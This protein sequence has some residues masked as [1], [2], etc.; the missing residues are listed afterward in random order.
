MKPYALIATGNTTEANRCQRILLNL[1]YQV[2]VVTT[3]ARAQVQ[4]AFSTPD[5]ILLDMDL[6]DMPGE[7]VLRQINAQRRMDTTALILFSSSVE[8]IPEVHRKAP[9]HNLAHPVNLQQLSTFAASLSS[10]A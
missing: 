3:G 8:F 10:A 5:L 4:L 2:Q 6:P 1:G 9:A 7:V